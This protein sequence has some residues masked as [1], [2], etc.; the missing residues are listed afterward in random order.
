MGVENPKFR[1]C[2]FYTFWRVLILKK[3]FLNV[4]VR[5]SFCLSETTLQLE[6]KELKTS[7]VVRAFL[8]RV[9]RHNKVFEKIAHAKGSCHRTFLVLKVFLKNEKSYGLGQIWYTSS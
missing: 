6:L 4:G 3:W 5:L 9:G 7:N 1:F 2:V 8:V